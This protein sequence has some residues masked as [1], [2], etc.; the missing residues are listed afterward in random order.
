MIPMSY[1]DISS[2][3]FTIVGAMACDMCL[4]GNLVG[5]RIRLYLYVIDDNIC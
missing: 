4:S 2:I 3:D 1:A 5:A